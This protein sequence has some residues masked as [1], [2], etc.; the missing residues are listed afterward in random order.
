MDNEYL[1]KLGK[2]YLIALTCKFYNL[3]LDKICKI[4]TSIK[5]ISSTNLRKVINFPTLYTGYNYMV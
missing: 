3:F 2:E 1:C 5:R 4:L